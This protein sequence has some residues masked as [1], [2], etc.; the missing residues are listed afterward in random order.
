MIYGQT[1]S[2]EKICIS[3]F[4]IFTELT[5][6]VQWPTESFHFER[7]P[8]DISLIAAYDICTM[9]RMKDEYLTIIP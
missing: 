7:P 9:T 6:L 5:E 3:V 4:Y 2:H 8:S 1:P